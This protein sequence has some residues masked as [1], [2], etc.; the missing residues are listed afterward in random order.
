MREWMMNACMCA[1]QSHDS[2]ELVGLSAPKT[3]ASSGIWFPQLVSVSCA[4]RA[5]NHSAGGTR[6]ASK[7][8]SKLSPPPREPSRQKVHMWSTSSCVPP[9]S[10]PVF[11][12][13][14]P[15]PVVRA[16]LEETGVCGGRGGCSK[17]ILQT[18]GSPSPEVSGPLGSP[19][20]CCGKGQGHIGG[21]PGRQQVPPSPS[22]SGPAV[23]HHPGAPGV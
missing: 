23:G 22:H 18:Q 6:V 1:F 21:G 9:T 5:G 12:V 7:G 17:R 20:G 14:P 19:G 16:A 2:S 8:R 10:C 13:W 4:Y 11:A 15:S 3:S